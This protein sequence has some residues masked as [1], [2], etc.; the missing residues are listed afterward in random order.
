MVRAPGIESSAT[1]WATTR[2]TEIFAN[3]HRALAAAAV[4]R[5][6]LTLAFA[7]SQRRMISQHIMALNAGVECI[8]AFEAHGHD[9]E[10][11]VIVDTSSLVGQPNT[12]NGHLTRFPLLSSKLSRGFNMKNQRTARNKVSHC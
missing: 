2:A 6:C 1:E 5:L 12:S 9:I 11:R 4:D 7:P 3:R 10:I 8:A